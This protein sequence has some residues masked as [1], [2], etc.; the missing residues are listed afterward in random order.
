MLKNTCFGCK[1]CTPTFCYRGLNMVIRC[2]RIL[3]KY[4]GKVDYIFPEIFDCKLKP[5][6]SIRIL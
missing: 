3:K 2:N 4:N 5:Y 6:D 1:H